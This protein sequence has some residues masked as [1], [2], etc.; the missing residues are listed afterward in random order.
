TRCGSSWASWVP[1]RQPRWWRCCTSAPAVSR[2]SHWSWPPSRSS[3]WAAR[4][5]SPTARRS[6]SRSYGQRQCLFRPARAGFPPEPNGSCWPETGRVACSSTATRPFVVLCDRAIHACDDHALRCER[7]QCLVGGLH[8]AIRR[9]CREGFLPGS[10][11]R[12]LAV[13]GGAVLE[14]VRVLHRVQHL[15]EP[16]QRIL[17][18]VEQRVKA[19]LHEPAVGNVADVGL[20]LARRQALHR[21][22]LEC[23]VDKRVLMIHDGGAGQVDLPPQILGPYLLIFL[24]EGAEQADD[25]LAVQRLVTHRPGDDLPHPLHLPEA[26]EVQQDCEGGEQLQ[27]LGER[28]EGSKRLGDLELRVDREALHIVIFVLHLLVAQECLVLEFRHADRI[29]EMAV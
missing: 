12:G 17:L 4:C 7:R 16:G 13:L 5:S 25:R 10:G 11:R 22:L 8:T 23:Q 28:A 26:G 27:P 6:C 19:E 15:I 14:E 21:S 29:Q 9:D 24:Y 3:P 18:D 2:S 1:R 20:D